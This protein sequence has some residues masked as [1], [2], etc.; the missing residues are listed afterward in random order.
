MQRI[1][2]IGHGY[3]IRL[4]VIRAVASLGCEIVVIHVGRP[5]KP[6]DGYSRYVSEVLY[7]N[8]RDGEEGLVRLLLEKCA[9]TGQKPIII[10]TDDFSAL[11][12][13]N[14]EVKKH[15]ATP[16]INNHNSQFPSPLSE[17]GGRR[18][19]CVL[20]S[21]FSI[22]HWMD[23][24]RQKELAL[25]V[26]LNTAGSVIVEKKGEGFPIPDGIK[27]PCF[28][29][30]VSSIGAGK[31]CQRRC[32][33]PEELKAVL[34]LADKNGITRVLVEDFITISHEYAVLGFSDGNEVVIPGVIKFLKESKTHRG[35]AMSGEVLPIKGFEDQIDKFTEFIRQMGFVGI[36]DIDFL[37]SNGVY[38]FDEINLRTGGSGTAIFSSGVN[39]PA[40]LVKAMCGGPTDD[41]AQT[42]THWAAFVNEKMAFD[43]FT[44]GK[45]SSYEYRK[46][47]AEA[48]IFF[49]KD[50][51]DVAPYNEF[52]KQVKKQLFN[53]KRIA[54]RV[55]H[56]FGT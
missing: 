37:E 18:L 8:R 43:D 52:E 25:S 12:I 32:N 17:R 41:K 51:T 50:D 33:T 5:V 42:I 31:K 46:L 45:M 4:G 53:Y 56:V 34:A 10:P 20:N 1:I 24:S 27:Y 16:H 38:Y 36:F 49:I 55:L 2:V 22:G 48:D 15:F 40:M 21:Q 6:I 13:D 14:E 44:E 7:F 3:S 35:V 11:A 9:V 47:L 29:K 19:G 23:K 54:K 39:L 28:T 30:P 26:G